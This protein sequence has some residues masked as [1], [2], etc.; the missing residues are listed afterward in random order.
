[1]KKVFITGADGF[2]GQ[3]LIRE[4]RRRNVDYMGAVIKK[5][6]LLEEDKQVVTDI[7]DYSSIESVLDGYQPD[8]IIHLAAIA[9]VTFG[10]LSELYRVNV[11]GAENVLLAAKKVC[12]K[13]IRIIMISSAGVYGI[14]K[15]EYLSECL[16]FNPVNHYS[17][18]KMVL[19]VI[20]RQYKEY[21]DVK[22]VRPFT[23]V[24]KE[25][26]T[27]FFVSKLVEKFAKKEPVLELGNIESIRDYTDVELCGY[28]LA[29]LATR[30]HVEEEVLNICT[31]IGTKGTEVVEILKRLT[32]F[33]PQINISDKYVRDNEIWRLVG[34]NASIKRFLKSDYQYKTLEEILKE[35][36]NSY[37]NM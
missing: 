36:L 20:C 7:T 24:G 23:I 32:G 11:C 25:Q 5:T 21:F 18:T 1:M 29:E 13:G 37:K 16:P 22:I 4:L 14:Q 15:E 19:E 31:G 3:N 27:S 33:E 10:N 12:K 8:V 2:I 30:E 9:S 28:T 6:K 34:D 17:Y 26:S 35:M